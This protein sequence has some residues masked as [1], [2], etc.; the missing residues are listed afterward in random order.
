MIL[1]YFDKHIL[2]LLIGI[3]DTEHI[4]LTL[5]AGNVIPTC[6]MAP[7]NTNGV[8]FSSFKVSHAQTK[9]VSLILGTLS[10]DQISIGFNGILPVENALQNRHTEACIQGGNSIEIWNIVKFDLHSRNRS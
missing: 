7:I 3:I 9:T 4:E 6:Y 5:D 1:K 8:Y 10:P 2:S